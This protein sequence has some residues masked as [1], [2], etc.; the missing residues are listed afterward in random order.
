MCILFCFCMVCSGFCLRAQS[1]TQRAGRA[2]SQTF[3]TVLTSVGTLH[4]SLQGTH[5]ALKSEV[6]SIVLLGAICFE[7]LVF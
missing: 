7:L 5:E 4:R 2:L 6:F 3:G 1:E